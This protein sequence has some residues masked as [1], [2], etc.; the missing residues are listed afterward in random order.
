LKNRIEPPK[1]PIEEFYDKHKKI[2]LSILSFLC[3]FFCATSIVTFGLAGPAF[4]NSNQNTGTLSC[5]VAMLF[6]IGVFALLSLVMINITNYEVPKRIDIVFATLTTLLFFVFIALIFGFL[7]NIAIIYVAIITALV[8]LI[9]FKVPMCFFSKF[10]KLIAI[11]ITF[12]ENFFL[13][14]LEAICAMYII[15]CT[16]KFFPSLARTE[17]ENANEVQTYYDVLKEATVDGTASTIVYVFLIILFVLLM[18]AI[19]V[20]WSYFSNASKSKA[21]KPSISESDASKPNSQDTE[22][23]C[24]KPPKI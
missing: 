6:A 4:F 5:P 16:L 18:S 21:S 22:N 13:P 11:F 20:L 19:F 17:V 24:Q 7:T 8:A 2:I 9:I 15:K 10:H 14:A 12:Y 1:N 3:K 23:K